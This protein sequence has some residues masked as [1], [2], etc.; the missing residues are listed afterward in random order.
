MNN[1]LATNEELLILTIREMQ[2]LLKK[3]RRKNIPEKDEILS[4]INFA[5]EELYAL[6]KE[7]GKEN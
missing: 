6:W 5:K 4:A 1:Q 2:V 3:I 7:M